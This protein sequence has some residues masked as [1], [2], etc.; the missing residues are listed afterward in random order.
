MAMRVGV[1]LAIR[2]LQQQQQQSQNGLRVSSLSRSSRTF[3]GRTTNT[4]RSLSSS[5]PNSDSNSN[6]RAATMTDISPHKS[7][8]SKMWDKYSPQ[9]QQR[10]IEMG[11]RLFRSAQRRANDPYVILSLFN[12][13]VFLS[14]LLCSSLSVCTGI[15]N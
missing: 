14:S 4:T 5:V 2:S 7:I 9:G 3:L 11:E 8:F 12:C 15:P 1:K 6:D 13:I 10:N